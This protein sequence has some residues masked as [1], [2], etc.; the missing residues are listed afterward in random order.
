MPTITKLYS[1]KEASQHNTQEDCWVVIDGRVPSFCLALYLVCRVI[2][3]FWVNTILFSFLFGEPGCNLFFLLLI[4]KGSSLHHFD[5]R[6]LPFPDG[7]LCWLSFSMLMLVNPIRGRPWAPIVVSLLSSLSSFSLLYY[8]FVCF[9][10]DE[11]SLNFIWGLQVSFFSCEN[12]SLYW[13]YHFLYPFP[14]FF[15][16]QSR[17]ESSADFLTLIVLRKF[18]VYLV[19]Q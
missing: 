18:E 16:N 5:I 14:R 3:S 17:G 2:R 13:D 7:K 11:L 19:I 15:W 12:F 9:V 10:L 8:V 1:M 4:G 6:I